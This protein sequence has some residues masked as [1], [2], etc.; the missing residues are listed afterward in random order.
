MTLKD[1]YHTWIF[2]SN[3]GEH[4]RLFQLFIQQKTFQQKALSCI[5]GC[6]PEAVLCQV[7]Q[8]GQHR[9][10]CPQPWLAAPCQLLH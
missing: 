4:S 3:T 8:Q 6:S 1:E 2:Q 7:R 5:S 10:C 9:S